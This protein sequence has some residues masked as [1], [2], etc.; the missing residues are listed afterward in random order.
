[1]VTLLAAVANFED[2]EQLRH[3]AG[4]IQ[5]TLGVVEIVEEVV[6]AFPA[7]ADCA[8]LNIPNELGIE[9]IHAL[10]VA[11][12]AFDETELRKHCAQKLQ[13]VFTPVRFVAV[14]RIPRN[15]MAKIERGRVIELMKL[16]AG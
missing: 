10:I 14:E 7:I 11:R 13:R 5:H 15:D 3:V 2:V 9:E 6:A 8:V 12:A 4:E 1:M 16:T